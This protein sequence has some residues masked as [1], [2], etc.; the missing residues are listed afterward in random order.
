VKLSDATSCFLDILRILAALT[1]FAVHA[2]VLLY[3]VRPDSQFVYK[4]GHHAVT[5]FFVLSGFFIAYST[6]GKV[7]DARAYALARLSRLYSVVVPAL[8]LTII[9]QFVG[10]MIIPTVYTD[11][12]RKWET[13]RYALTIT[14][15]HEVWQ[16]NAY[17]GANPPFWSLSY[18]FWYYCI[19][20]IM[21]FIRPVGIKILTLCFVCALVGVKILA[22]LPVWGL[23][24]IAYFCRQAAAGKNASMTIFFVSAA[25]YICTVVYLPNWPWELLRPPLQFSN[26]FLTD[27]VSGF[28]L[29]CSIW[30]FDCAFGNLSLPQFVRVG[31]KWAAGHTFSLYLYHFPLLLFVSAVLPFNSYSPWAVS[32][33]AV[34]VIACVLV[35]SEY[36]EMKRSY[37]HGIFAKG[38]E[39]IAGRMRNRRAAL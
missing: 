5:V 27:W 16:L 24:V 14:F 3:E 11:Y 13:V 38:W 35:L 39:L 6:L 23:G 17:P 15:L 7:T 2:F 29:A 10:T 25:L 18:E 26:A 21:V 19:F 32:L 8:I 20:G 36:T 30:S 9:L 31:V 22:L 33:V 4:V 1:V 28:F 37:W 12:V 34:L